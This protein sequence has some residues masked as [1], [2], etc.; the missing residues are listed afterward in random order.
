MPAVAGVILSLQIRR[1]LM[2][3]SKRGRKGGADVPGGCEGGGDVAGEKLRPEDTEEN[4]MTALGKGEHKATVE[5]L[6]LTVQSEGRT[7]IFN[8][9]EVLHAC[10]V[11]AESF[12][13]RDD[14]RAYAYEGDGSS[15]GSLSSAFSGLRGEQVD[16][17][18]TKQL[19]PYFLDV[20]DLIKNLPEATRSPTLQTRC[21]AKVQNVCD[22]TE[23]Q[24][25]TDE[26]T[27]GT[28][29]MALQP[30]ASQTD[31]TPADGK[32]SATCISVSPG[33]SAS[34][35]SPKPPETDLTGAVNRKT[36][37]SVNEDSNHRTQP[38][39]KAKRAQRRDDGGWHEATKVL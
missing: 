22:N 30:L 7:K 4:E 28:Q 10:G 23:P 20:V 29:S 31:V 13:A 6:S 21:R 33:F 17:A 34:E 11:A 36:T 5:Y 24:K 19:V 18:A 3:R 38:G 35:V 14:L 27:M 2:K 32:T 26:D 8:K 12:T 16:E 25:Q 15:A 37:Y 39:S 9:V 1:H